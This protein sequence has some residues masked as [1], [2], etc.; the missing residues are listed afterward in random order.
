MER[1]G[2]RKGKGDRRRESRRIEGGRGWKESLR[3]GRNWNWRWST[4]HLSLRRLSPRRRRRRNESLR[5]RRSWRRS[6]EHLSLRSL[7][8]RLRRNIRRRLFSRPIKHPPT[9]HRR[10]AA[11]AARLTARGTRSST[12]DTSWSRR[13]E[14]RWVG[15]L[16]GAIARRTASLR[17]TLV[18]W[19]KDSASVGGGGARRRTRTISVRKIS[20]GVFT[21]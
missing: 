13:V 19:W 16:D 12:H 2:K 1:K 9:H 18:E 5:L 3:L 20:P 15:W 10:V 4:E 11:A 6:T 7:V 8:L 14:D 21:K 17:A